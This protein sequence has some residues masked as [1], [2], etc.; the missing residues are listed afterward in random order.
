MPKTTDPRVAR[1]R[2]VLARHRLQ[3]MSR[4]K[5]AAGAETKAR[6]AGAEAKAR[7][8]GAEAKAR[9]AGAEAKARIAAEE[10]K[11]R[12]A[13]AG[14]K[15]RIAAKEAKARIKCSE[16]EKT[17]L[18]FFRLYDSV[19]GFKAVVYG[20]YGDDGSVVRLDS[21]TLNSPT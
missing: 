13:G 19:A 2:K 16:P 10:T 5:S 8:A 20:F 18:D 9:I 17:P 21:P 12:I 3:I 14:A 6:I 11:A 4:Q 15:A 1:G 7:I